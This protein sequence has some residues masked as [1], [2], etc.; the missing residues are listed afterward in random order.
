MLFR[1][2]KLNAVLGLDAAAPTPRR[3]ATLGEGG[4]VDLDDEIPWHEPKEQKAAAPKPQMELATT[5][6]DDDDDVSFFKKL[7]SK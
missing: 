7:A 6:E 5:A 2:R 4:A 3:P 1:S